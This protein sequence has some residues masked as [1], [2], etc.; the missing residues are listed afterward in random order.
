MK[1]SL[2]FVAA[3]LALLPLCAQPLSRASFLTPTPNADVVVPFRYLD[4]GKP[5]PIEWGLD[6]AWLSNDNVRRGIAFA[7]KELIDVIRTSYRPT[8]SVEEGA[9][10]SS[11]RN[12]IQRRTSIIKSR[13]KSGVEL[14]LNCD[15]PSVDEWYNDAE[16]TSEERGK[17]WAQVINLHIKRYAELGLTNFVTISP[18]NEPDF[19]WDQ[20]LASSRQADFLN[21]CL[22]LRNDFD[23]AYAGVRLCGGNT[24]NCDQA[25]SWWEYLRSGLDEGNTHQLAGSFANYASF[26]QR[27]RA[28][29]HHATADELHNTMEAM[30]GVEYGLQTGIWWGT[31]E[32][33]RSQFMK[34]TYHANPGSRL[35]Y[36]EHRNN[37]TAA[38]IYRQADGRVQAFGGTSE[39]QAVA[40][41][42]RFASLDRPVW[43]NGLPGREYVM[44]LPGG[45]GYQTGQTNAETVIDVQSGPDIMPHID[46]TYKI[47]NLGSGMLMG[48]SSAATTWNSVKQ[49]RNSTSA[50]L[51]W[52]VTPVPLTIGDDFSYY[53]ITLNSGSGLELDVLNWGLDAGTDVGTYP[54]G[55]GACEQW[56]LEYAGQ[57]AFYI[58]S[59]HSA[60][61]LEVANSSTTAGGNIRQGSFTGQPNQQWRLLPID[62]A[63]DL[64]SP[65]APSNLVATPQVSSVRLTWEPSE[66]TDVASYTLLRSDDGTDYYAIATGITAT[67]FIDNEA[68][69]SQLHYYQVYAV[70]RSLN[71]SERTAPATAQ[72][73][74]EPGLVMRLPFDTTLADT[75]ANANHAALYGTP[76]WVTGKMANALQLSGTDNFVQLPYTVANHDSLTIATWVLWKGT[77]SWQR[78][79]AFGNDAD[80]LLYFTPRSASGMC[81]GI[82][83]GDNEQTLRYSR[84]LTLNRWV[85]VAVT[86]GS[87]GATLYIDGEAVATNPDITILPTDINPVFNYIGRSHTTSDPFFRGSVD[88]FRIYNYPLSAQEIATLVAETSD[89]IMAP[90]SSRLTPDGP[91]YDLSGRRLTN[92]RQQRMN[93]GVYIRNGKKF[94]VK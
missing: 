4:E 1:R 80:H 47:V 89:G 65:A 72:A 37:W 78:L 46:G 81:F 7:G 45:K 88:D 9:L 24:L 26:F 28:Y 25:Y 43:Y 20:G 15:H 38:A 86:L 54:G 40:T 76:S 12:Y 16:V 53:F 44:T 62:V 34:A 68:S 5:T 67:E 18:F 91:T 17:R 75:T 63:P 52:Q 10:S 69:D 74:A 66:S 23:G 8:E 32:H 84:N 59:R 2:T 85:H 6:L 29:G 51:Q 19:G 83:N 3:L 90:S 33:S 27:V 21:T 55:R 36:G 70:D 50:T 82:K 71:Y 87:Q 57:G 35:A 22:S 11:Q 92:A 77:S 39:R 48:V 64:Q 31:C 56:F 41:T 30:V 42:Y 94:V 13:A 79:W 49:Y 73:S 14:V 58:R 60:L 61:Y 93:K